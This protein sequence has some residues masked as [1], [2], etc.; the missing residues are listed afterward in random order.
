MPEITIPVAG[1]ALAIV[2]D[3][4][5][6]EVERL[7]TRGNAASFIPNGR[8]MLSGSCRTRI[9]KVLAPTEAIPR[10]ER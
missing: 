10:S 4:L 6:D 5:R 8:Q 1:R 9:P 7:E 2:R 3:Q